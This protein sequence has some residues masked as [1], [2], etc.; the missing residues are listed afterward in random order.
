[1]PLS[2]TA[3]RAAKPKEKTYLMTDREGVYLEIT[4]AGGK[5]WRFKFRFLAICRP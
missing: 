1:M 3:I 2:G 5:W 4:P